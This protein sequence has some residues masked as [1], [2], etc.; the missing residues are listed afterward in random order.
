VLGGGSSGEHFVGALRRLDAD[1]EVTVVER[2]LVGGECSYYACMPT[3]TMLRSPE[4]VAAAAHSDGAVTGAALDAQRIFAWRDWVAERDDASQ[5]EWLAS[6]NAELVRGDAV[7]E[8]PGL[9][10]V[11]ERELRYDRLVVATGS[12]PAIPP[13]EGLDTVDYWT[14]VEAT[15]TL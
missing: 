9:V 11:G 7:V 15:E 6:Q 1:S 5:V 2:R 4:L 14:N 10:R 8:E 3:K 13:V 12:S